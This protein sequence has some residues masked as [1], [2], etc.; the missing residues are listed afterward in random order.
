MAAEAALDGAKASNP[1][2]TRI[3]AEQPSHELAIRSEFF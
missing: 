3:R 2:A 1:D